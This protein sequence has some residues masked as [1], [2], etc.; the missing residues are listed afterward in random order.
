MIR[1]LL[2]DFDGLIL[3]TETCIYHS[4]QELYESFGARLEPSAWARQVGIITNE[5]DHLADL[6]GLVGKPIDR[7]NLAPR[8]RQRELE[9]INFQPAC[10]GVQDYLQDARRLGL[11]TGLASSA[12]CS[13]VT[14]HLERLDLIGYFD[15]I[16]ASDDVR[17]VKPDPELYLAVLDA[18]AVTAAEALALEDS[19]AGVHA[20]QRAGIFCVAVPN[21]LT[22]LLS[23][24]HADLCLDSLADVRL[25][26]LIQQ[27]DGLKKGRL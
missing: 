20:A 17:Q 9:L 21:S 27:V 7:S 10:P 23:L 18:L 12:P 5:G 22:R 16:W 1:A 19:P 3:D 26:V 15:I 13:W 25:E 2:F 24:G 6:E 11:K 4:W 14:G 8:R